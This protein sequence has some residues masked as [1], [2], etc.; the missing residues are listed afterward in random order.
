M[1]Q[2]RG[3]IVDNQTT[4]TVCVSNVNDVT[5][6]EEADLSQLGCM[7]DPVYE[8][9]ADWITKFLDSP[10]F[11]H[12]EN[13]QSPGTN[14]TICIT[15]D[16]GILHVGVFFLFFL[17]ELVVQKLHHNAGLSLSSKGKKPSV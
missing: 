15:E 11:S 7:D 16:R 1:E 17:E 3:Q 14:A 13:L 5:Q 10:C 4:T 6:V 12:F 2:L 9:A 8:H